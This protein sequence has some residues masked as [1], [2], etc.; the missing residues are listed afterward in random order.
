MVK[1]F[2]IYY[3]YEVRSGA[4]Q[5]N[6]FIETTFTSKKEAKKYLKDFAVIHHPLYSNYQF[7]ILKTYSKI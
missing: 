6:R 1:Y 4:Y 5:Y 3:L 7:I 2:Q